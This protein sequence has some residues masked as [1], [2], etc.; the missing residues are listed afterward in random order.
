MQ[1]NQVRKHFTDK[2]T[3][4]ELYHGDI[5]TENFICYV[6]EDKDRGLQQ[7][8]SAGEIMTLK[9]KA[10]TAI[11]YGKY[12]IVKTFSN[13]F[14][15][16]MP[17]LANV[18]GF[19]GIRIHKGNTDKDTEGCLI[20]GLSMGSDTVGQSTQATE[21]VYKLIDDALVKKELIYITIIKKLNGL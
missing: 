18:K 3:I 20:P 16:E 8:M 5:K 14:Q 13:R 6:L 9:V 1:F 2:S 10:L 15:K 21:K 11:P 17:M 12:Q 4:S 19:E 7:S